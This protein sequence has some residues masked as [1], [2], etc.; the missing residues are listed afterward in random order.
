MHSVFVMSGNTP[1][2]TGHVAYSTENVSVLGFRRTLRSA[3]CFMSNM[4]ERNKAN[5]PA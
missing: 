5:E 1:T 3:W 4:V 2:D